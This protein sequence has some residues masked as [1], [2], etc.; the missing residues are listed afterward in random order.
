MPRS[1]TAAAGLL[2]GQIVTVAAYAQHAGVPALPQ[3]LPCS[4]CHTCEKPT[5]SD[6]CLRTC[7]RTPGAAIAAEMSREHGPDVVILDELEELYLPVPF[8][9]RGHAEMTM[10]T[11]GCRVCHHHSPEGSEHP[12]CK[13]CH[14]ISVQREDMRKP[15]LK[16]AYHRQC[17]NCHRE[18]SGET[19]CVLCHPPK[20]GATEAPTVGS[21]LKEMYKEHPPIP[22]PVEEIYQ[23]KSKP[24]PGEKVIFRHKE[25]TRRF[26][27]KC[28][29][30]HR[31]DSCA[32]CHETGPEGKEHVQR[33]RT[34]E[35]HH[36]PCAN[37]HDMDNKDA[38]DRCH[39][40]EGKAK[41]K[42]F[43]HADAGWPLSK[44]HTKLACRT[45]H[46]EIP[47]QKLNRECDD[48]HSDWKVHTFK[49]AVTGQVLDENH[50]EA[51]C[52]D[53]HAG[54]KF[55]RPPKCDECHEE[56]E[57]I[58]FPAQRPGP[59]AIPSRRESAGSAGE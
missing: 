8:D 49:H 50:E 15:S 32:R 51:D 46:G 33:E 18:W 4:F 29:E 22:E 59:L 56:D 41:P 5:R 28:A 43:D 23:P 24:P 13:S 1:A 53:C 26:G 37:C 35:E 39:W 34:L 6:P 57:G 21:I 20:A 2:M 10:M 27:L 48:C 3:E 16:A 14:E 52:S 25:H 12:E 55:D 31:E 58:A 17:M 40:K 44:Y 54:R 9:H 7:P 45:C 11:D 38:C 30:C 47:F 36:Q 42:A 19:K